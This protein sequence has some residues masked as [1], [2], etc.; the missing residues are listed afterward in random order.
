MK[1]GVNT[2]PV[3]VT[4][5]NRP[6]HAARVLNAVA[7][8]K[9]GQ[10]FLAVD[11]P[12]SGVATDRAGVEGCRDLA[13]RIDWECDV[14]TRF[15][16]ENLGCR[17][18]MIDGVSWFFDHV[19]S[20]VVLEDDCLPDPGFATFFDRALTA[21]RDET[22]VVQVSG[23]SHEKRFLNQSYFLPLSSSWGWA[24]WR[25]RWR[26]YLEIHEDVA[27]QI[28]ADPAMCR[29]F[30]LDGTYPYSKML[31]RSRNG[32]VSSWAVFF[33]A[34]VFWKKGL[35]L[36]PPKS[37]IQNIGFDG[38]GAHCRDRQSDEESIEPVSVDRF[39]LPRRVRCSRWM[40]KH[41]KNRI[42]RR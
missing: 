29:A 32:E 24:T 19:E 41:V 40:L 12:R 31:R 11:G 13:S 6:D 25:D 21:Y 35:V 1:P 17:R 9:P 3:L 14:R 8:A 4:M 7:K 26:E 36:Y 28:L 42:R 15:S 27:D 2:P 37:L 23:Y 39:R 18:G 33:Q 30:D 16:E 10:L 22:R 20:G 34:F 5:F 38:S